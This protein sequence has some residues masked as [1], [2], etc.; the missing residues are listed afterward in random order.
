MTVAGRP[1][2]VPPSGD[3][4]N[5]YDHSSIPR[6]VAVTIGLVMACLIACERKSV[7]PH[8]DHNADQLP[9][10]SK[11]PD[12]QLTNQLGAPVS[13]ASYQGQIWLADIIFTRCPGPCPLMTQAMAQLAE[14]LPEKPAIHFVTL[15]T[16]PSHDTP[17]ILRQYAARF[18]SNTNR[19]D[20]LTG[21]SVIISKLATEG[22]KLAAVGKNPDDRENP[23]DLF[24]HST[25]FVLIDQ[26]GRMRA[27]F[28][29]TKPGLLDKVQIAIRE[30]QNEETP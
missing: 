20:F 14:T 23:L 3:G 28:D 22:M 15:T 10:I 9:I 24:I 25:R 6:K 19:W 16:D 2:P 5:Q 12:F 21:D 26:Q 29:S 13:L 8:A 1:Q 18:A 30:M 17:E 4:M 7:E 27:V 11:L